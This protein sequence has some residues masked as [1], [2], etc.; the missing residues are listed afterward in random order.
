ME[1]VES[2]L[3]IT[4]GMT[5]LTTKAAVLWAMATSGYGPWERLNAGN[6]KL[7]RFI[8]RWSLAGLEFSSIR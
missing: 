5:G 4:N 1:P 3:A 2:L 7:H 8:C 6:E